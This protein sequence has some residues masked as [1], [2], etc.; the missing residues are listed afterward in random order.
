MNDSS[1]LVEPNARRASK[2]QTEHSKTVRDLTDLKVKKIRA[3]D[4][5]TSQPLFD[6]G[7]ASRRGWDSSFIRHDSLDEMTLLLK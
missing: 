6:R 7:A 2:T 4:C 5:H 1:Q 3:A